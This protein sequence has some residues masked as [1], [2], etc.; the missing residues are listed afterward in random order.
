MCWM[1]PACAPAQSGEEPATA[2]ESASQAPATSKGGTVAGG[3]AVEIEAL[4][5]ESEAQDGFTV[6]SEEFNA[7]NPGIK[8][9]FACSNRA[10]GE[11]WK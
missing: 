9:T 11:I 3:Q 8:V 4:S 10:T 5:W 2:Q 1:L 7:K 6:L